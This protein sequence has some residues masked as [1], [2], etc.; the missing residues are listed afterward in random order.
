MMTGLSR[1]TG[2]RLLQLIPVLFGVTLL[3]YALMYFSPGD[4]AQK[5]LTAGGVAVSQEVLDAAR[6]NMGISQSFPAQYGRWLLG[7]LRGDL[8]TSYKDGLPV[9]QKLGKGLKN[10]LILSLTSFLVS[11]VLAIP[12]GIYAALR[13]D[14]MADRMIRLLGFAGN[15]MPSFLI[16]VLLM[17]FF[18]IKMKTFPVVAHESAAGLFLPIITLALPITGRVLRQVR[19]E[20]LGELKHPYVWGARARG[21]REHFIIFGNV[22]HN[23]M[24]A[25][26]TVLGLEIGSLMTGSVVVETIFMWPGVGK[27]MMDSITARDYPVIQGIVIMMAVVYV[28]VNLAADIGCRILDPRIQGEEEQNG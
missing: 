2:K 5:K 22:L 17:Y 1:Y 8:G 25:I 26:L 4:P 13:K 10:T 23:V 11:V 21:I 12:L 6:E 28:L 24:P 20:I 27:L 9:I 14:K 3:V 15:S 7:A 19:A 18:C 16:A